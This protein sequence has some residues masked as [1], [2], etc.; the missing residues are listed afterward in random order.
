M[1]KPAR[2]TI[3]LMFSCAVANVSGAWEWAPPAGPAVLATGSGWGEWLGWGLVAALG[4]ALLANRRLLRL[5]DRRAQELLAKEERY[6]TLFENAAG[7]VYRSTAD[8]RFIAV[9]PAL[10]RMMG[11]D[12]P[13][14]M[15]AW[16]GGNLD[17]KIYA[18]PGRRTEF[19]AQLGNGSSL[20][21]FESEVR[22]RDGRALWVSDNVRGVRDAAGTLLH[23]EGFVSDITPRRQLETELQRAS[24]LEAIGI[25]AGGIAHDF[26]N[27][28]TVVL[29]NITLAELDTGT[30]G[31]A[32]DLLREAKRATLR[33]RDL[34]Q[35]LLTFAK[36]GD[37]V[38][39]AVDLAGLL[40]EAAGFALHG[41]KA[42]A[43]YDLPGGL[44]PADADKGQIGQ[45]VQN[46]VINSVQAMPQGGTVSLSAA[47][48]TLA[49]G[50]GPGGLPA[51]RYI[52]I[53]V[54]DTGVGIA[55]EHLGKI[56]DP[57][58]TTKQQGS[59]LG[60]A[61]VYSIVRK[62][63]GHI[64][65]DSRLGAGTTFHLWLPAASELPVPIET[66]PASISPFPIRVLFMDDEPTIRQMAGL[67]F[68]R[69]GATGEMAADG[70]DALTKYRASHEAGR[71][72]DVVIMD[73]TV[74][75]GMGGREAM[76]KLRAYD[77]EVKAIVSS[78]YSRDPVL[79]N[80][81]LHGFRGI[82]PKPYGL[83]QL[84]RALRELTDGA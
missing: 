67:F 75:G 73:L 35:Q 8:G 76:E 7:G 84:R 64:E 56:F 54:T 41:S 55:P 29:G 53:A 17:T 11:F 3:W 83:K 65:V 26:N 19:L 14:E 49:T 71:P 28:L 27:I 6:R 31:P 9:N 48:V 23:L 80:Y 66:R 2:S 57:Y 43:E 74:P 1:R 16:Y 40:R 36:G 69:L 52:R 72:F 63:H 24:K 81:R 39:A 5:V 79:A 59:G 70:D 21:N 46:L 22:R 10:A 45:V 33:A 50:P 15:I 25:L 58:F 60:L 61:S 30:Q 32:A 78:G 37:P 20:I 18:K 42:R 82:L 12:T 44:W 38:R 68:E 47:N 77:P 13:E 34:T 51:G 4:I 62:H